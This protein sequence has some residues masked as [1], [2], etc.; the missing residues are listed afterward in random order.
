MNYEQVEKATSE[1]LREAV[2]SR[3]DLIARDKR[4]GNI[5][6]AFETQFYMAEMDRREAKIERKGKAGAS[7]IETS[8]WNWSSFSLSPSNL[9]LRPGASF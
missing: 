8:V 2:K 5:M 4:M 9:S 3:F 7:Q 6:T 1:T